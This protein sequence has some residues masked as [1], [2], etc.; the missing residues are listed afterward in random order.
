MPFL[1]A[2]AEDISFFP[3]EPGKCK[4]HIA[5]AGLADFFKQKVF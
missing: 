4:K 3:D 5:A 1:P 2:Q